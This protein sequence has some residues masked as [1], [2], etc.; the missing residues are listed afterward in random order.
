M[1]RKEQA[2]GIVKSA[3]NAVDDIASKMDEKVSPSVLISPKILS[4]EAEILGDRFPY[5]FKI[6]LF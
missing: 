5:Y 6:F 4:K 1:S 2:A 3:E